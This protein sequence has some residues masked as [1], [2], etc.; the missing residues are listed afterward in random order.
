LV[1]QAP[2]DRCEQLLGVHRFPQHARKLIFAHGSCIAGHD[3]DGH[4]AETLGRH[5]AV[6]VQSVQA[7]KTEVEDDR[8]WNFGFDVAERVDAVFHREHGEAVG[9]QRGPIE[10]ARLG[11]VFYNQ[12]DRRA[13]SG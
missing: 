9:A 3:D 11:V 2:A 4:V 1:A 7:G 13:S 10:L 6:N 8:G 12:D 5:L